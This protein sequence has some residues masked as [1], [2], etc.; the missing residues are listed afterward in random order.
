VR[1]IAA[2]G[3]GEKASVRIESLRQVE[4]W[5]ECDAR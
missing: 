5:T 3:R 2:C 4:R 1:I